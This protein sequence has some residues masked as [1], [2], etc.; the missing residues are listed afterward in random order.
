M[1]Q[2]SILVV[3]DERDIA[4]FIGFVLKREGY[5]VEIAGDGQS[6]LDSLA[7]NPV[8]LVIT[9]VMMPIM[10]GLEL[11]KAL[12]AEGTLQR[13]PVLVMSA[14]DERVVRSRCQVDY[15]FLAKPFKGSQLLESV[16]ALLESMDQAPHS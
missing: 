9:D 8:D 2:K 5:L 13:T 6:A 16:Q 12:V 14:V 3:E 4:D 1:Q 10:D 7:R 15:S 11:V